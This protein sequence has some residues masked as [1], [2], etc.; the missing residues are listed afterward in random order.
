[1]SLIAAERIKLVSTRSPWWCAGLAIVA[2]VGLSA[3]IAV[4]TNNEGQPAT[5]GSTQFGYTLGMAVVMVMATLAV[6]TEYSVGTIRTTFMAVPGRTPA[7][8]AKAVVVAVLAAVIGLVG[9]FGAWGVSLALL[10]DADLSLSGADAWRQVAGVGLVYLIAAVI[11][12][13]VGIL[14]RHTAGAVSVVLVWALMAEQLFELIPGVGDA[15]RPWLPFRA[16]KDFL[17][18]EGPTSDGL[19]GGGPWLA[20]AYFTVVAGG[21]LAVAI[22]V[23]RR[24]DA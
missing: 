13:A 1:M 8:L 23:A 17:T 9:A 14:V 5:V 22:A 10:P 4:S 19:L 20:L 18:V 15:V 21:L 16:A 6:T 12:V 2:S 24:R 11:A 3:L 7:L